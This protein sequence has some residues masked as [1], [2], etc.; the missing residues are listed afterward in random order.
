MFV[1]MILLC[2]NT[3]CKLLKKDFESLGSCETEIN[4]VVTNLAEEVKG[5]TKL[6]YKCEAKG[7]NA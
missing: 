4:L 5:L 2:V 6:K 7:T 3:E 1:G